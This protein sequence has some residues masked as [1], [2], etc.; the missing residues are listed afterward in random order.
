MIY[1]TIIKTVD[2]VHVAVAEKRK[3]VKAQRHWKRRIQSTDAVRPEKKLLFVFEEEVLDTVTGG[4]G[5]AYQ[6]A[7]GCH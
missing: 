1:W 5:I 3:D 4:A 7:K 2:G 6:S